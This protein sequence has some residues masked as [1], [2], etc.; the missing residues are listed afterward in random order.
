MT[1]LEFNNKDVE[2]RVKEWTAEPYDAATREEIGALANAGQKDELMDRFYQTLAFGTGGLRGKLGAGT[3][4]MN[5]Y[6][7]ARATQ[8]LATYVREHREKGGPLRAAIAHD[9]R[10]R[11]R[12]FAETTAEVFAGNGFEVF[13]SPELRPTPYLSFAV[14]HL[15][16]HTGVVITASHNPKEYNGYKAYWDDG[17]QVV[18]PHDKGIIVEVN[19]VVSDDQ[20]KRIPFKEAVAQGR[21]IIMGEEMDEAYLKAILKQRY[22]DEVIRRNGPRMVF[23]PLHGVGGTLAP[24]AF[25]MWGFGDVL[26]EEEQMK[27]NGNFPTAASPNP[28]EGAALDR[29][30]KL[31]QKEKGELVLATDPDADRLGIAVLHEGKYRLMT[32]NQVASLM[33]NFVIEQSIQRKLVSGKPGVATTIVSSPLIQKVAEGHGAECPLVLTGFKWIA[34]VARRWE[35]KPGSPQF[36]MGTEESYGY[37]VGDHCRDKDGIV[38]ACVVGE[39]AALAKSKGRTLVDDLYELFSRHGIHHEW[40]VSITMPGMSGAERMK[41]ILDQVQSN[42]PREVGGRKVVRYANYR[43]GEVFQGGKKTGETGLPKSDVFI[44]DLEDGSR[45]IVRPSGTEPKIKF[46]FFLCDRNAPKGSAAIAK[47]EQ[48]LQS[49]AKEFEQQFFKAIGYEG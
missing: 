40:Q 24:K 30:I 13:I 48:E 9:S 41:A 37:L 42:P 10:N 5:S 36:L 1:T 8:G 15:N 3:N 39:M 17:S 12:E 28:E 19:K 16:C 44:F 2:A 21:I 33:I 45:G 11:S 14:R 4:R 35:A 7:V 23:T 46:Y 25:E 43:S 22:D 31:A 18:P 20:V 49:R 34:E 38:A 6:I 29:A 47:A 27:P 32:G 26:F